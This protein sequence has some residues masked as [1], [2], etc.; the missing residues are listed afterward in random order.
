MMLLPEEL[1]VS[2][3]NFITT[4]ASLS[5][6]MKVLGGDNGESRCSGGT[7]KWRNVWHLAPRAG[8]DRVLGWVAKQSTLEL[9]CELSWI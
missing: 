8:L 6:S 9:T 2:K 4:K 7:I 3:V 5:R 1:Q